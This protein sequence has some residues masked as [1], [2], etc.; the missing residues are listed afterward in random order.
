MKGP[1]FISCKVSNKNKYYLHIRPIKNTENISNITP[2][3]K[4]TTQIYFYILLYIWH[5]QQNQMILYLL[6]EWIYQTLQFSICCAVKN[7]VSIKLKIEIKCLKD[8]K[9]RKYALILSLQVKLK[10]KLRK[11]NTISDY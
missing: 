5:F 4:S 2:I 1:L 8:A 11:A 3:L 6:D 10:K 9:N 7:L